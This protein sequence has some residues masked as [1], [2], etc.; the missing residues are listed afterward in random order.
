MNRAVLGKLSKNVTSVVISFYC[1]NELLE[2]RKI[3]SKFRQAVEQDKLIHAYGEM[4][5]KYG[6]LVED[7]LT[8]FSTRFAEIKE[9]TKGLERVDIECVMKAFFKYYAILPPKLV[10]SEHMKSPELM[11]LNL[12]LTYQSG[13]KMLNQLMI[14]GI[15]LF[16]DFFGESC[17]TL[18]NKN[19]KIHQLLITWNKFTSERLSKEFFDCIQNNSFIQTVEFSGKMKKPD[20][21]K[22]QNFI[23]MS[24]SLKNLSLNLTNCLDYESLAENIYNSKIKK[25][26]INCSSGG[27]SNLAGLF[28][29]LLLIDMTKKSNNPYII[30][31]F[32]NSPLRGDEL[33]LLSEALLIN[34]NIKKLVL[35]NGNIANRI[36]VLATAIQSNSSLVNLNLESNHISDEGLC[37]LSKSIKNHPSLECLNLSCNKFTAEGIEVFST[38]LENNNVLTYLSLSDCRL[39][40]EALCYLFKAVESCS[41]LSYLF[42][43]NTKIS[44]PSFVSLSETVKLN[45]SL[46]HLFLSECLLKGSNFTLFVEGVSLSK[47]NQ[48]VLSKNTLTIKDVKHLAIM[49][50]TNTYITYLDLSSIRITD[51]GLAYISNMLLYNTILSHLFLSYIWIQPE[52]VKIFGKALKRNK[53]IIQLSISE[54]Y[55]GDVGAKYLFKSIR[56]HSSLKYLD[57]G[58]NGITNEGIKAFSEIVMEENEVLEKVDLSKNLIDNKGM[59][60]LAKGILKNKAMKSI[61]LEDNSITRCGI[62]VLMHP[63][64]INH[65]L[66]IKGHKIMFEEE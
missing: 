26:K 4:M 6:K 22:V 65:K 3:S 14:K 60:F 54:N 19:S 30:L 53:T 37:Q 21:E 12:A 64:R 59:T 33:N 45:S 50:K 41:K 27:C 28:E 9:D 62:E 16:D 39:D 10:I 57:I 11:I 52:G 49:M 5:R 24:P 47:L 36:N 63:L 20:V 51:N 58:Y 18:L 43:N 55:I 31:D 42:L 17:K 23:K 35:S 48:L 61:D 8:L 66:K 1:Q 46:T 2:L 32:R 56:K 40:E 34:P 13:S 7:N 15:S 44:V 29:H 25:L 38:C